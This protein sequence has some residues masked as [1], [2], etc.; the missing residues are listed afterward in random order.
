[1]CIRDSR[2]LNRFQAQ[3][4]IA[5]GQHTIDLKKISALQDLAR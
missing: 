3:G 4:I 1:M 2:I 5:L